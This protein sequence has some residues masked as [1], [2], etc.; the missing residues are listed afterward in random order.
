M[1]AAQAA[2]APP[3][4]FDTQRCPAFGPR[5]VHVGSPFQN[6]SKTGWLRLSIPVYGKAFVEGCHNVG[7]KEK[8]GGS[9]RFALLRQKACLFKSNVFRLFC[10]FVY[11]KTKGNVFVLC[12]CCMAVC[13]HRE[14]YDEENLHRLLGIALYAERCHPACFFFSA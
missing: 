14:T 5:V 7:E 11:I 9:R 4:I 10:F 1:Y 6:S 13:R 8:T 2:N 12:L 3:M